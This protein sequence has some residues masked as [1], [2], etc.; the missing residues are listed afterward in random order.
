MKKLHYKMYKSGKRWCYAALVTVIAGAGLT[1]ASGTA[2]ADTNSDQAVPA[3]TQT[4][5]ADSSISATS[6]NAS[7]ENS[8]QS[9]TNVATK[10]EVAATNTKEQVV[11]VKGTDNSQKAKTSTGQ[12][13]SISE[14]LAKG[15]GQTVQNTNGVQK[16][17]GNYYYYK[18]GVK[19]T[20]QFYN[21]PQNHKTYYFGPDGAR[22]DNRFYNNWGNTYYFG[23]DGA[24][25]DNRFMVKWGNAYYFTN[26][27]SLMKNQTRDI[28][29]TRYAANNEGIIPL[30]NQFLTA[31]EDQLF[32]FDQN[33]KL[34][35]NMFYHNWGNT[36]YFGKDGARYTNQFLTLNGK[37]YYFDNN[38][39]MYRDRYYK[40]W[41]RTYYFGKDGARYTN[42]F[43][44]KNGKVYYYGG[45]GAMYQNQYY[46]NWG[47]TYYFGVDG[48]RYTNQFMNKNGKLY[49]FGKDGAM[50]QGQYYKNWGNTYYFGADGA[51]YTNQ[52]LNKAGKVYYFDGRGIMYQDRYY[53][54][55]GHA[56]YFGKDGVRYTNQFLNKA[57]KV[58][59]FDNQ[60]IMYQDQY[61]KNWGH[62]YYFGKDGARY[63]NQFLNKDGHVYYFDNQ[64]I[65]YQNQWYHN[66]GKSYYFKADGARATNEIAKVGNDYYYFNDQGVMMANYFLTK[67]GHTYYF[68]QNGKEYRNKFY[69]N[70]GRT[71][72][73][74]DD[75]ARWDNKWMD[76]WGHHYYFKADGVRAT[77]ETLS[78]NGFNVTFDKDGIA[79]K[80]Y[81]FDSIRDH[82][83]SQIADT[84]KQQRNANVLYDWTSQVHNYQELAAHDMAQL[85]AQGYVNDDP[86]VIA[87]LFEKNNLLQGKVITTKVAN[88]ANQSITINNFVDDL[89]HGISKSTDV[90]NSVVGVGYDSKN[91][92]LAVL[93]F[94]PEKVTTPVKVSSTLKAN[95]SNVYPASGSNVT[96][97]NPLMVNTTLPMDA[98]VGGLNQFNSSLLAGDQNTAISEDVLK[99]IFAGLGGNTVALDGTQTY[100]A[101]NGDPYH[102]EFWLDGKNADEKLNDFLTLN[103]EAKYGDPIKVNY[104]ATLT[105]GGA[106]KAAADHTPASAKTRDQIDLAYQTGAETGL[107]YDRVNVEKLPGMTDDMIRGVDV[108]SYQAL[109]NAGVKFYDFNGH[110]ADLFQVLHDAGVNW[111]RLRIWNDPYNAAGLGYGGGNNDEESLLKMAQDASK[112]GMK[113]LVDFHYSD[114]W[115]DP[116]KQP[117]PKA[118]KN[119]SSTDLNQEIYLYTNKVLKDLEKAGV[120]IGMVQ[121]GNEVTNGVFGIWTDRDHGGN[122]ATT[123]ESA[124]GNKIA[125]YLATAASAVRNAAPSAKIAIQLETPNI[126]KYRSIMTVLKNN[127]VDYDYL[128]TSY[129]PFWSTHDG[130]GWYDN[131]DLGWG[132]STPISLEGIE[133]MAW[134]EFGKK[135][136]VLETGWINNVND[137]DG[138]GNS[139]G[140]DSEIQAY[141]HDPQGQVDAL[142]DM[143][144]ALIA[145]G[146]VGGFYWE[147]AWI[148]D[149]AG[150]QNWDYN[151][152]MSDVY[153]TGWANKN[154]VGYAPDSVMFWNGQPTWG[155]T[156]WDNVTLFD[157]NGHP[158]QSLNVYKGLL[159]G[160]KS[161]ENKQSQLNVTVTKIWNSTDVKP[162]DGL[163]AGSS[164]NSDQFT[165]AAVKGLLEGQDGQPIGKDTLTQIAEQLG[166]GVSSKIYTAANGAKYHYVYWL[167]GDANKVSTFV[168]ANKDAKYGQP[169]K[170]TYSATVVVDAEPDVVTATSPIKLR[171]SKIWNTVAGKE[172]YINNPLTTGSWLNGN[173][174]DLSSVNSTAVTNKL[175]GAK[176]SDISSATL[177]AVKDLLPQEL[178]GK[179][180]YRTADGN[181]Y[182]YDFWIQSVDGN[183]KYGDPVTV[184]YSASLKWSKKDA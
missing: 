55:W 29:G 12:I 135:T 158:L 45:D 142:T 139:I 74:G 24:R 180:D 30:R 60:G 53:K 95:I 58:Y 119:L 39:V 59:Y 162:N 69:T 136:V 145:Q 121:V 88:L 94:K 114:F 52:F 151:K 33:G 80:G 63:T 7:Q 181:H 91:N 170:A 146:G 78:I 128:G 38:G 89:V 143:Y 83:A 34:V 57:G 96:V 54:N 77:N 13:S 17:D 56:Y 112:H 182:Y 27:G 26:D 116:A 129:Y 23:N 107:Q 134:R 6:H 79:T 42:Q 8:A 155:G 140:A 122:W 120:N 18:D 104:T 11:P 183:A 66:W 49:Y 133:K 10:N 84:L 166:N 81:V 50:Y 40:N 82:V 41:G 68:D 125:K 123:W 138:T 111:I 152:K 37:V 102:Y 184:N 21:D 149:K 98:V 167:T 106:K 4:I 31:N 99:T 164:I 127:H 9:V 32:Y 131:V 171:V 173:D 64:G 174:V 75:G 47:H 85:L 93:L 137:A 168:N 169:L 61:Y 132:A 141:S 87:S 92:K 161:P 105:W 97:K 103:H 110:E 3:T 147:P 36:Y 118:W 178:T 130:N 28:N 51:R 16:E 115:A 70:W 100:Y 154:A 159:E 5:Q 90:N 156:T 101:A 20:N 160:Y 175:T 176:G 22:W 126:N 67:D 71:Y 157:D 179:K 1:I 153:G 113:V 48:A 150:W 163:A 117:L 177:D 72:Y 109:L 43:M 14:K 165:N 86:T 15:N 25:W 46:K 76:A 19:Q 35:T 62:T 108:S 172:V 124:D 2:L 148:P 144:R 73:F 44:N 65:M